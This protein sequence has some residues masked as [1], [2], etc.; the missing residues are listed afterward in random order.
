MDRHNPAASA[1][2]TFDNVSET[3]ARAS[4]KANPADVVKT[5]PEGKANDVSN[6]QNPAVKLTSEQAGIL[7]RADLANLAQKVKQGKTL[8]AS[9]RNLLQSALAGDKPSAVEYAKNAVELANLLGVDRRT[10]SRWRKIDGNPG[11]QPDGR[12]HVPSWRAFKISQRGDEVL[13]DGHHDGLSQ[14]QLRARQILLQNQKLEIQIA[15]LK[16]EFMPVAEVEKLGGELGTAIRKVVTQ[17]H[18]C[19]PSV[20][21]VS[22]ADAEARLKEVE[23]EILQQ[24]HLLADSIAHWRASSDESDS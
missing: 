14:T 24:L 17:I 19:A 1:Q 15:V 20:V 5:Q 9:E 4:F 16:R 6:E 18:L 3:S 10:I 2:K 22:V 7:L 8:S 23:D 13:A 12:Y 11:V 21:G